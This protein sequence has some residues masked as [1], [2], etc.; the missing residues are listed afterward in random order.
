MR[1]PGTEGAQ[2]SLA[3]AIAYARRG[4]G[5]RRR[6]AFGWAG[7]TPVEQKVAELAADGLSNP[8]IAAELFMARGTVKAHLSNIYVKLSVANR[9]ELAASANRRA[10]NG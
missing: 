8:Q 3:E 7:L 5:P 2:L 4:R 10:T 1:S 6:T 9:T